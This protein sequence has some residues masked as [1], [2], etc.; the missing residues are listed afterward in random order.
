MKKICFITTIPLTIEAFILKTAE[1][2]HQHTDWEI[3]FLCDDDPDFAKKVPEY[4]RY[5][6]VPM[7]RGISPAGIGAMLQMKK[8]FREERFDLIQYSTPNASLYAAMAGKAA[9]IPVRLYC[10][11][12]MVFVGFSGV[13]RRI[14]RGVEKYVC[15]SSTRIEPD[16]HRNMEFAIGEGLYPREKAAVIWNGS[17]RGV[18]TEKYDSSRK[19]VWREE[20]RT[21]YG[22]PEEAFVFG[23]AGRITSNKGINELL[24]AFREILSERGVNESGEKALAYLMLVGSE[25]VDERI[26]RELYE[27]S[28]AS[29]QVIY[30]GYTT[31]VEKYLAAMDCYVMPSYREGLCMS[32]VEAEVMGLPVIVTDIPGTVDAMDPGKT[33]VT[34]KKADAKD[35][36]SA[37]KA[38]LDREYDIDRFGK[39]AIDFA[40]SHFEQQTLFRYILEDR[41]ELLGE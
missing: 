35:L 12:G 36:A 1:Y 14:F 37:M 28:R 21:Q 19:S 39:N 17:S 31:S 41:K 3:S 20:I 38:F 30:T 29:E 32:I 22:I 34:V 4:I 10:Q 5:F 26:D 7:K 2:L 13:K 24:S 27:W 40:I 6:P 23:F 9:R 8:I 11:W 18:D 25:E 15:K 16:S 33:G